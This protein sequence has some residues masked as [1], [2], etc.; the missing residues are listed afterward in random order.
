MLLVCNIWF[1]VVCSD[2]QLVVQLVVRLASEFG[3]GVALGCGCRLQV[4]MGAEYL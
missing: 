3:H 1:A 4:G 2:K